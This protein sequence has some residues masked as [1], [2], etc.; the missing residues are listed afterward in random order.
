M[1]S[2]Q[3][4]AVRYEIIS[5]S[6]WYGFG[7]HSNLKLTHAC[8]LTHTH[9]HSCARKE[10]RA[11]AKNCVNKYWNSR[12]SWCAVCT[13]QNR[14]HTFL[15][16][17]VNRIETNQMDERCQ[18]SIKMKWNHSNNVTHNCRFIWICA[19]LTWSDFY[20]N[21]YFVRFSISCSIGLHCMQKWTPLINSINTY[22]MVNRF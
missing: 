2:D 15:L 4:K 5:I 11:R 21:S 20:V 9:T 3:N 18:G 1:K 19:P 12:W 22:I 7:W 10:K 17:N 14:I 8:T 16:S 13:G 6:D